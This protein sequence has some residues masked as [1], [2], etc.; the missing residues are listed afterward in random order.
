M[1][2]LSSNNKKEDSEIIKEIITQI[3]NLK[4]NISEIKEK[5]LLNKDILKIDENIKKFIF[6]NLKECKDSLGY[7]NENLNENIQNKINNNSEVYH[8]NKISEKNKER[9]IITIPHISELDYFT[10]R[11]IQKEH[12]SITIEIEKRTMKKIKDNEKNKNESVAKFLMDIAYLSRKS[13][14]K[15]KVILSLIIKNYENKFGENF[16]FN[17][18]NDKKKLSSFVKKNKENI[19]YEQYLEIDHNNFFLIHEQKYYEKLFIK[20]S[21]FYFHCKLAFPPIEI[22]FKINKDEFDQE[23][24]IDNLNLGNGKVNFAYLPSLYSNESFLQNAKLWVYT[25]NEKEFYFDEKSINNL[26]EI[27]N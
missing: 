27:L 25:Y 24:M 5:I 26:N 9:K 4:K 16:N 18:E 1:G 13:F 15:S 14:I 2:N 21:I 7:I 22:N 12:K 8:Q 11:D 20:L 3:N 23:T 6:V 10:S 19:L 17:D